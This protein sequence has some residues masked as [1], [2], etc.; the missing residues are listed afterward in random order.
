MGGEGGF[1]FG[2][3]QWATVL[4]LFLATLIGYI[5]RS[6]V[7]VSLSFISKDFGWTTSQ[8]GALG[9]LLLGVF[10]VSYGL[11]NILISPMIDV[12]GPRKVLLAA[13]LV[14]S[15]LTFLTGI[16]CVFYWMFIFVRFLLGLSQG[17]LFPSAS[18]VTQREFPPSE[19]SRVNGAY[20]ASMYASNLIISLFLLPL[21]MATNWQFVFFVVAVLGFILLIPVWYVLDDGASAQVRPSRKELWADVVT[22]LRRSSH[23]KGFWRIVAA[24][25]GSNIVFWGLSLWLPSYLEAAKGFS[26]SDVVWAAAI[27]YVGGL[28]GVLVGSYLSDRSARRSEIS[29]VFLLF[30]SM[31]LVMLMYASDQAV[32][33]LAVSLI[34]F[35]TSLLSAN[36]FTFVQAVAPKEL[37]GSATGLLNGVSNGI[38]VIGPLVLGFALAFTGSYDL[39]IAFMAVTLLVASYSVYSFRRYE[40]EVPDL[41]VREQ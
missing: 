5:A 28:L 7:S 1:R 31:S 34:F 25:G 6:S 36:A 30:G 23:I 15:V 38:G 20:L 14:W 2:R 11:S 35:F 29:C 37:V 17:V 13:V 33:I 4:T 12:Y 18:K 3:H 22:G 8:Q 10:L 26:V 27:P 19:R 39:G 32:V 40:R 24:D 21:I 16:I 9:G 41:V